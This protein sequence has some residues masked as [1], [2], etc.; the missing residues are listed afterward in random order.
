MTGVNDYN[1][2]GRLEDWFSC[3]SQI[4]VK[5]EDPPSYSGSMCDLT[6]AATG[7]MAPQRIT[8]IGADMGKS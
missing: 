4:N 7:L 6:S 3:L 8:G 2:S 1:I 5:Y